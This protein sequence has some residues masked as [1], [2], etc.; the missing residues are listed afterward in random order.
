MSPSAPPTKPMREEPPGPD[1][2]SA[3]PVRKGGV[4]RGG[5]G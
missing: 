1:K 3:T 2:E 4:M 5:G